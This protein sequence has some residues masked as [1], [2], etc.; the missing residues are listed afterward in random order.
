MIEEIKKRDDVKLY[1]INLENRE[2]VVEK[3]LQDIRNVGN[4]FPRG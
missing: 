3:I 4:G 1:C 2:P